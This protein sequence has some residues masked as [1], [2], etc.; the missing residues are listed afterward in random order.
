MI[1]VA[2]AA[3]LAQAIAVEID[4]AKFHVDKSGIRPGGGS[5][6]IKLAPSLFETLKNIVGTAVGSLAGLGR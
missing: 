1:L 6:A 4:G 5:D 3:A 2:T